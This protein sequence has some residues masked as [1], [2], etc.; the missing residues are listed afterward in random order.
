MQ[1][2]IKDAVRP[3]RQERSR[4]TYER[5]LDTTEDL[6][7]DLPF[8][9]ISIGEI[10]RQAGTS[11][12]AFYARFR[13]KEALL[14]ALYERYDLWIRA[15]AERAAKARPWQGS[16]LAGVVD[17]VVGELIAIFRHRRFMMRAVA[18]HARVHPQ[19]IDAATRRRRTKEM[20][21]LQEAFLEHREEIGHPSPERAVEVVLFMAATLIRETVLFGEAPHAAATRLSLRELEQEAARM[22]LGYLKTP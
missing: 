4:R 16:D 5:V 9:A 12:G 22:V 15:R 3:P 13:D 2:A 10:V 1:Q 8:E 17:W 20:G 21:F 14:P 11:V 7:R 18:L 19:K 6:L